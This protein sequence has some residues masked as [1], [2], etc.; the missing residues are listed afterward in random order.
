EGRS[1][2]PLGVRTGHRRAW[3]P[4][5]LTPSRFL[6][7]S[8]AGAADGSGERPRAAA[9]K[10]ED[11]ADQTVV[12]PCSL[13]LRQPVAKPAAAKKQISIGFAQTQ[14]FKPSKAAPPQAHHVGATH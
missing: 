4:L 14:H 8:G 10:S 12:R 7:R 2:G 13:D 5:D 9:D 11:A 6:F 3:M 1:V